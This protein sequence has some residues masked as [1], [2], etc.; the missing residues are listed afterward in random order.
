MEPNIVLH[1][2][3]DFSLEHFHSC[4]S[5]YKTHETFPPLK[6]YSLHTSLSFKIEIEQNKLL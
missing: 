2:H 5:I 1:G 3:M 6:I 4:Q